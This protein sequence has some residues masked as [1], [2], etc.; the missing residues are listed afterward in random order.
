MEKYYRP[1]KLAIGT[2]K[3]LLTR[4]ELNAIFGNIE[5]LLPLNL[6]LLSSLRKEGP[7]G[8]IG[9]VFL[10]IAPFLKMYHVY[11]DNADESGKAVR[12]RIMRETSM[13]ALKATSGGQFDLL[14]SKKKGVTF[15]AFCKRMHVETGEQLQSLLIKPV[16]R[17]PRYRMLIE[18][19]LKYTPKDAVN[20]HARLEAALNSVRETASHVNQS[21]RDKQEKIEIME[22]HQRFKDL[23]LPP[24]RRF[25]DRKLIHEGVLTKYDQ[26]GASIFG[27]GSKNRDF[28]LFS[29]GL[30]YC[31][32]SAISGQ[33]SLKLWF[34]LFYLSAG[35]IAGEE[36]LMR[37][38]GIAVPPNLI[39]PLLR[40]SR[41]LSEEYS[42]D[43]LEPHQT[44]L[45]VETP[46][47]KEWIQRFRYAFKMTGRVSQT[48]RQIFFKALSPRALMRE[49]EKLD[50]RSKSV[51]VANN[52]NVV[53]QALHRITAHRRLDHSQ[54]SGASVA[55]PRVWDCEDITQAPICLEGSL[56]KLAR[57]SRRNWKT[58]H[59][60]LIAPF[61]ASRAAL[62][63][64]KVMTDRE[65][66][67]RDDEDEE[68]KS[69]DGR[70]RGLLVGMLVYYSDIWSTKSKGWIR[71]GAS[72][73]VKSSVKDGKDC[74]FEITCDVGERL[75]LQAESIE[76]MQQ[77]RRAIEDVITRVVDVTISERVKELTMDNTGSQRALFLS[78]EMV[79]QADGLPSSLPPPP[80]GMFTTAESKASSLLATA[81]AL[82]SRKEFGAATVLFK[83]ACQLT[84]SS[85]ANTR[86]ARTR[87]PALGFRCLLC[88]A[89]CYSAWLRVALTVA[90]RE[91]GRPN[92]ESVSSNG[93]RIP[94][95]DGQ[96][97]VII[98]TPDTLR[99]AGIAE[100]LFG[101]AIV[102]LGLVMPIL[103]S[104]A[105]EYPVRRIRR[106]IATTIHALG[107]LY[108]WIDEQEMHLALLRMS[109]K[110]PANPLRAA[111]E[112]NQ[113]CEQYLG[114]ELESLHSV[115][116]PG[117]HMSPVYPMKGVD[118]RT[119]SRTRAGS[120]FAH[121]P[122]D[123][124]VSS[125]KSISSTSSTVSFQQSI[126][127]DI[128][129]DPAPSR[130]KIRK[131][132]DVSRSVTAGAD[133]LL[134]AI[135]PI[136]KVDRVER[137]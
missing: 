39:E 66:S 86:N 37:I 105:R 21:I 88:F 129:L 26:H 9:G 76:L 78:Q 90:S 43:E 54:T 99:L 38:T 116:T 85:D 36:K 94:G 29:D 95:A 87:D 62:R 121:T 51:F 127:N 137:S 123:M 80:K 11:L 73:V 15:R 7:E 34:P 79:K 68:M 59:F 22:L 40:P 19:L 31:D 131:P 77:W 117:S 108:A 2:P 104:R 64:L 120:S 107:G 70:P 63:K 126:S 32:R 25:G 56:N 1:L 33:L 27:V 93:S 3:Q 119:R 58:R 115:G 49:R 12:K 50:K 13:I 6:E 122:S 69:N 57:V 74:V 41:R 23:H 67:E 28:F 5:N 91:T 52:D 8:D 4:Q 16:Q 83:K 89:Q 24:E 61:Y 42:R 30:A 102:E 84:A 101:S 17:I 124:S 53:K 110:P 125:E 71:L 46:H 81:K 130:P 103:K 55:R 106:W 113:M 136:A 45:L 65:L 14:E 111:S 72:S 134:D 96:P 128:K 35:R 100:E 112:I 135:S 44:S 60:K 109:H 132:L 114:H 47:V 20:E 48:G 18:Q 92:R 10:K 118:G 133:I 75:Y 97:L 98:K 82:Q